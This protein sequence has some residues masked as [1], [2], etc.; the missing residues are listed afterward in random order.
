MNL[1]DTRG[2]GARHRGTA[3]GGGEDGKRRRERCVSDEE[4]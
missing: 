3:R 4:G 2:E 1:L